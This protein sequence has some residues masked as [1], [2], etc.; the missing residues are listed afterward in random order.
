MNEELLI[1]W[2]NIKNNTQVRQSVSKIRS[3][4]KNGNIHDEFAKL[5]Y[6]NENV[7]TEQM[8]S[9]D[10]KTRKNTAL[11]IGDMA[12]CYLGNDMADMLMELL[13]NSYKKERQLFVKPSYLTA[14]G[15]FDY[16]TYIDKLKKDFKELEKQPG[17][18]ENKKH[19]DEQKRI[20]SNMLIDIEGVKRHRFTGGNVLSNIILTA[21]RK[22]VDTVAEQLLTIDGI[23]KTR[24][25]TFPAGVMAATDKLDEIMNIRT[26]DEMLFRVAGMTV[27]DNDSML[28]AKQIADGDLLKFLNKRHDNR[29]ERPYYFRVEL[30]SKMDM[31]SKSVF[32]KKFSNALENYTDRK[33]I[34]SKSEYEFELRLIENKDGKFNCMVKLYTHNDNRFAYR[35]ESSATSMKPVNAA[36]IVELSRK[37]MKEDAQVLDPFCGTATLLIERQ[38]EVKGNTSY[39]IDISADNIEKAKINTEAAGQI[40]HFIN[41]D[42]FEFTHEY[43]FDEIITDMPFETANK[44]H[45]DIRQ[46]Y[47]L[48]FTNAGR[49]LKNDGVII[50]YTHN[51]EFVKEYAKAAG[52]EILEHQIIFEKAGTDLYIM[53]VSD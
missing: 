49:Y 25:K 45:E 53:R 23:D 10:A 13:Y 17:V 7:L 32:V 2:N 19:N 24:I 16:R 29:E 21:N 18:P 47:R 20:I 28:A 35:I 43:L 39:G 40:I 9:D 34:N 8:D 14:L 38:K 33:L 1:F 27:L 42:F 3:L 44:S 15:N 46:V 51:R 4:I 37:Y 5:L 48:F 26:F 30:R 11:L 12:D 31:R 22:H 50:M 36:L 52:F 41:K 6:G